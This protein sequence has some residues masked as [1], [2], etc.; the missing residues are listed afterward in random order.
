MGFKKTVYL[1]LIS[2][3]IFTFL[4]GCHESDQTT[5]SAS[6]NEES[7]NASSDARPTSIS[8]IAPSP[9]PEMYNIQPID[10]KQVIG[11]FPMNDAVVVMETTRI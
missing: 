5:Y 4:I 7:T 9:T 11:I 8:I 1:S 6:V 3:M 2:L 10:T